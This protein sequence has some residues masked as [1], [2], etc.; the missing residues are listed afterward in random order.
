[1]NA[2]LARSIASRPGQEEAIRVVVGSLDNRW[3]AAPLGRGA[4]AISTLS[5]AHGWIRIAPAKEGL[6]AGSSVQ[7]ELLKPKA[8]LEKAVL[9]AG[10]NDLT[11]SIVD[12]ILGIKS[13]GASLNVF[14]TGSLAGLSALARGEAHLSG[15]HL[16]DPAS[17]TYNVVDIKRVL[18]NRE[19]AL[20]TLAH[21]QQGLCLRAD[22][23]YKPKSLSDVA[24]QG[25]VWINRQPGSGTRVLTESLMAH[26]GIAS[27]DFS[28]WEHEEFTHVAV[29]E[30]VHSNVADCGL[31]IMAAAK[32][33]GLR[34]IPLAEERYDLII[35]QK[36]LSD[37]LIKLI[38]QIIN[39]K[40]FKQ[41][42]VS[43]GGYDS[44][45]TGKIR[46]IP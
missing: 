18:P 4:G 36:N 1:L 13:P 41:R 23:K 39:S 6:A 26:E 38:L 25:W 31:V 46:L 3:L 7:V 12:D 20:V 5:K 27:A 28:G 14:P 16:L 37:P 44:R 33:L 10:S 24:D 32:A 29:A 34:F 9:L 43:L 40:E 30:A 8:E 2:K 17:G 15:S 42:M 22:E 21:R 45:E 11:L 35:P 19:L